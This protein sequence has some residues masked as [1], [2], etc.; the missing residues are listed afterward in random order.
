M[1]N[2][3]GLTQ[4]EF[5]RQHC[6]AGSIAGAVANGSS[7]QK[8]APKPGRGQAHFAAHRERKLLYDGKAE[9]CS[10]VTARYARVG[11][12]E[13]FKDE[14]LLLWRDAWASVSN[15]EA[16]TP[17]GARRHFNDDAACLGKLHRIA[18]EIEENLA[19]APVVANHTRG[20]IAAN[21]TAISRP[22]SRALG[23]SSSATLCIV[24][25]GSNGADSSST[26]PASRRE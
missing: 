3:D 18:G 22:L 24:A 21:E 13:F 4:H 16:Q 2:S 6:G 20:R 25:S 19:Q 7:T 5:E 26:R 14:R 1:S 8:L 15:V 17:I 9:P 11:L 23:E 12:R 10:A